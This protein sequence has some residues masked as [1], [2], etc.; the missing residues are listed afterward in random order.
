MPEKG[1]LVQI[2]GKNQIEVF[3]QKLPEVKDDGIIM[4]VGLAGICGTDLHII[5]NADRKEFKSELPITLGHE[6]AGR[7][8]KMG[9]KANEVMLCDSPLKEGD[10]IVIYVFLPCNNCWWDK[11]FGSDHTLI[12]ED[13][14]PGY[15]SHSDKWPYFVGGWGEYM[16]V[17]PGTWIWKIP[18]DMSFEMAVLTEP[19]SMGI[20]AVEKALSLP[21][22]K[23]MQTMSFGGVV[24]VLGS[25]AIG[26]LTAIAAKIA[27]AGK[28]IL[29]GGPQ[30]SLQ[31]AKE[32]G[33]ADEIINIFETTPEERIEKVKKLSERGYGADVVFE[34]AGVP[35]A[36][37]EGLEMMR[38]LGTFVEL[39][40]L[41]DDGR[42]VSL[43]IARQIVQ[44]DIALYGVVSQPPQEFTK[45]LKTMQIFKD[46]FDFARIIT[47]K[48]PIE[49]AEEA[50]SLA[51]DPHNKG[52][53]TTFTGKAY[54][55]N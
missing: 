45:S 36:F 37:L 13:P 10:K 32:I 53:K 31:I 29:S 26:I 11:K 20:R 35:D 30:R 2:I 5:E 21:A 52:I 16:Y 24:A 40:C 41:I 50:V 17:Q 39:G 43:N 54:P 14:R 22:W 38:K 1:K 33:A 23:N 18:E 51:K 27:G 47:H 44:K 34:T 4:E 42:T 6:V 15:F 48:F 3:E 55:E 7:I 9:R 12:C 46:R 8:V 25:G 28:V 49:N 19:F